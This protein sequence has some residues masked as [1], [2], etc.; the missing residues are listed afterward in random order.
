MTG[1]RV[2]RGAFGIRGSG[3]MSRRGTGI[4]RASAGL[5]RTRA[6]ALFVLLA[7][8]IGL[9]GANASQAFAYRHLLLVGAS[10][11]PEATIR[12][13]LAVPDGVNLFRLSTDGMADRLRALPTVSEAAVEVALPD[14]LRVRLT[15]RS[16]IAVW[17]VGDQ[18]YLIDAD[19]VAFGLA[20][21]GTNLPVIVD[22]RTPNPPDGL[23]GGLDDAE[24]HPPAE[25]LGIGGT[26]DPVD[27]DAAS[28]LGSLRPVDI[29]SSAAGLH[30]TI[31][32]A[33]GFTI[34]TGKGGWSAVF[35]FYTPTIR[36]TDLI[37]GQVRLLR[38]LLA[39]RE[40]SIATV[41]LGDDRNGTYTLKVAP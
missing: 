1:R 30:L 23:P 19:G 16:A 39:G 40:E 10:L 37:P 4:K 6:L 8:G 35:G 22:R 28:R 32:D 18:G 26:V 11:T 27:F 12:H 34:D 2:T 15:E 36:Q 13:E 29:G 14:T 9:Y 3:G 20:A 7:S 21:S 25:I 41:V 5:N 17:Q 24:R 33:H 31:D 38:S